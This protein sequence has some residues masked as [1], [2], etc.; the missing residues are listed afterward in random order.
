MNT[1]QASAHKFV[2]VYESSPSPAPAQI[3]DFPG[4]F[5]LAHIASVNGAQELI[6]PLGCTFYEN[7][8][9]LGFNLTSFEGEFVTDGTHISDVG[10]EWGQRANIT[11]DSFRDNTR[12]FTRG[13]LNFVGP[14]HGVYG[15]WLVDFLPRLELARQA[16]GPN[17]DN[18]LIPMPYDTPKWYI[19]LAVKYF[20][21]PE[22]NVVLFDPHTE[23]LT[24]PDVAYPNHMHSADYH[25]N[26]A[27]YASF[28]EKFLD[29]HDIVPTIASGRKI[30]ISR[31][32]FEGLASGVPRLF[33]GRQT[34]EALAIE[35]GFEVIYPETLDFAEQ[36]ALF[37]SAKCIVGEYGSGLH[38]SIFSAPGATVGCISM[39]NSIQC[40]L[41]AVRDQ[42][43]SVLMPEVQSTNEKGVFVY[44]CKPE[45][46]AS[47]LDA[48]AV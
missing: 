24:F 35:K 22:E 21:L 2:T 41:A 7:A 32:H 20:G 13:A 45:S 29:A 38:N 11:P 8:S 16:L 44:D 47:F 42:K 12:T 27:A 3:V 15:H 10:I 23:R 40:R 17:Y 5:N 25:F 26:K 9:V 28:V 34:F 36:I 48:V 33:V 39:S 46:I 1:K 14:G 31:K 30:C 6:G 4:M 43:I 19:A 37:A 18:R